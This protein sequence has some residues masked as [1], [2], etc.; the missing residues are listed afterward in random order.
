MCEDR[1]GRGRKLGPIFN[2]TKRV[3]VCATLGRSWA[4]GIRRSYYRPPVMSCESIRSISST[5]IL[6]RTQ[7]HVRRLETRILSFH[8]PASIRRP[9]ATT[10]TP[11]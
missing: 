9:S 7:P 3:R 5:A 1:K 2:N 10:T 11:L 8:W 4:L 6:R